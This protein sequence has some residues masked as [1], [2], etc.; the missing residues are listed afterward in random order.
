MDENLW[1]QIVTKCGRLD[2]VHAGVLNPEIRIE[3][4]QIQHLLDY[5]RRNY[6]VVCADLSGNLE[7]YSMEIMHESRK[8][9]VVCTPESLHCT[10]PAR[11]CSTFSVWTWV[12]AHAFSSTAT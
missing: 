9:F 12:I 1:P 5:A 2:V 7:K 11:N 4:I 6:K 8:I 3:N 10:W